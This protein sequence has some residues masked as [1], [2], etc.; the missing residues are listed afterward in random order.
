VTRAGI[1]LAEGRTELQL[2]LPRRPTRLRV[3]SRADSVLAEEGHSRTGPLAERELEPA[4]EEGER[5]EIEVP[6]PR[7]APGK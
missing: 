6:A 3:R 4:P 2:L 7:Q 1:A 5:V